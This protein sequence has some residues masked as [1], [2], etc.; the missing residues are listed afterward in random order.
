MSSSV[1]WR[2]SGILGQSQPPGRKPFPF[3]GSEGVVADAE[4]ALW[5]G[6]GNEIVRFIHKEDG[7][8][9]VSGK[10]LLPASIRPGM[11]LRWDG[12]R[13]YFGGEDRR[14]YSFNPRERGAA[15]KTKLAAV[16]SDKTLSFAVTPAGLLNGFG[17]K[18]KVFTLAGDD[19][20]VFDETGA[21]RGIVLTLK[22]PADA[23]WYYCAV[24]IEPVTGD[25]LA[26]SEFP[27]PKIYRFDGSTSEITQ[28]WPRQQYA[29]D[30][31]LCDGSAWTV[32][33]GGAQTLPHAPLSRDAFAVHAEWTRWTRGLAQDPAGNYLMACSQGLILF[34]SK[35][36]AKNS[37][38]G[39]LPGVRNLAVSPDGALVAGVE[40]GQRMIRLA[41]DD[42][43]D[44]PLQCDNYEPWRTANGWQSR[45]AAIAWDRTKYL[46]LDEVQNRLWYFD[47]WHTGWQETPWMPLTPPQSFKNPRSLAVGNLYVWVLDDAGL[48][49][50]DRRNY[51]CV[52]NVKLPGVDDMKKVR[53]LAATG[54]EEIILG[55]DNRISA[56]SRRGQEGYS[57]RW[58]N[59]ESFKEI[60]A[61]AVVDGVLAAVDAAKSQIVFLDLQTGRVAGRITSNTVPGGMVPTTV[62]ASG[63]WIF[64]FDQAGSRILRFKLEKKL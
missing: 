38:I 30:I 24:G 1:Q 7:S 5:S 61:M 13:I 51:K 21:D 15:L 59:T 33:H 17:K 58:R 50:I 28:G 44:T 56:F 57:L 16:G 46:V 63:K 42:Q 34:D 27:D 22:R 60:T 48:I 4:G 35:G 19:V 12:R 47:P 37:R 43:P 14:I 8:Y 9:I 64:V 6:S 45:T 39:G 20:R 54:A 25:L 18:G 41:I 3:I 55:T 49:E 2:F 10:F 32:G 62:T 29:G 52:K 11:G 26:T 53:C 31:I 36:R 40:G 23:P